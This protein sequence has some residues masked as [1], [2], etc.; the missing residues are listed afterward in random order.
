MFHNTIDKNV[1]KSFLLF[2]LFLTFFF[3]CRSTKE[4]VS[5][6]PEPDFAARPKV[7][8]TSSGNS[9]PVRLK[10]QEVSGARGYEIQE[11]DTENFTSS[12]RNW[13]LRTNSFQLDKMR[14]PVVYVRVRSL[15]EDGTSRW[16]ETLQVSLKDGKI[17]L[18]WLR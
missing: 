6:A 9:L 15:F 12:L 14:S 17:H 7:L 1:K 8:I 5:A 11:S 4:E 2:L 16:S 18:Q 13:T 10:W 3:G